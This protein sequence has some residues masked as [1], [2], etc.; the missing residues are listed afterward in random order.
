[1]LMGNRCNF[2]RF[3]TLSYLHSQ[4]LFIVTNKIEL[5]ILMQIVLCFSLFNSFKRLIVISALLEY[6][7]VLCVMAFQVDRSFRSY[8]MLYK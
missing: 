6:L 5:A 8:L 7:M 3:L 1:M 4:F 2:S